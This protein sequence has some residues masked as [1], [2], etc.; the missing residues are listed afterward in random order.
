MGSGSSNLTKDEGND[1]I[2]NLEN[3]EEKN[4]ELVIQKILANPI[5]KERLKDDESTMKKFAKVLCI[6]S[7]M[8]INYLNTEWVETLDLVK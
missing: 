1:D 6:P 5:Y 3:S 8:K 7:E 2:N 4:I